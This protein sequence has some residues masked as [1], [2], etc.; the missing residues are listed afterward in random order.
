MAFF[1]IA[2][3]PN[4]SQKMFEA[5]FGM[6]F[7]SRPHGRF[8]RLSSYIKRGRNGE[9]STNLAQTEAL[10]RRV[11]HLD[12]ELYEYAKELLFGRFNRFFKEGL[13]EDEDPDWADGDDM[14]ND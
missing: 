7:R 8:N 6:E 1:G 11:N 13:D 10:I 9:N 5:A 2:E 14:F 4:V 12:V 3:F